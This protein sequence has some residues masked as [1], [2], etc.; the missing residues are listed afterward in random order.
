MELRHLRSLIAVIDNGGVRAAAAAEHIAQPAVTRHIHTLEREL[1]VN[2]FERSG[3][4]VRPTPAALELHSAIRPLLV[5]LDQAVDSVRAGS[6]TALR[7]GYIPPASR[8]PV[9]RLVTIARTLS[10]GIK[11]D[12]HELS[13]QPLLDQL[14]NGSL[15]LG[16]ALGTDVALPGFTATVVEDVHYVLAVSIKDPLVALESVPLASLTGRTIV[17]PAARE[18]T[19]QRMI[20]HI[21]GYATDLTLQDAFTLD[22]VLGLVSAGVGIAITPAELFADTPPPGIA[23]LDTQ[24]PLPTA[25]ITLVRPTRLNRLTRDIADAYI[26]TQARAASTD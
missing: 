5:A 6:S 21:R 17:T 14:R 23:L 22:A 24:P 12:L 9:P 7:V 25:A 16:F 10:P 18:P 15:D 11:I 8:G 2:L 4:G 3:R 26:S 13:N 19:H 1:G 20:D